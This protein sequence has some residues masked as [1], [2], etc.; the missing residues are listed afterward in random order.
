M[1]KLIGK[2]SEATTTT[3]TTT[4][5]KEMFVRNKLCENIKS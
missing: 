4:K 5:K 3:A 2:T 1:R